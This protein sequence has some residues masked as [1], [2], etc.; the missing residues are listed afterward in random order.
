VARIL[1]AGGRV[2]GVGIGGGEELAARLVIADVMPNALL[3]MTGEALSGWYRK[4]LCRYVY[5]PATLKVDW[6]L[7]GPIPRLNDEVAGAG[8]VHVAGSEQELR[9]TI[10][11]S[12]TG[13]PPRPSPCR[14]SS[15]H[16]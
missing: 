9:S 2:R 16:R 10:A 1:S 15:T 5:G 6:A 8:T 4:A 12:A 3:P 7:A 14:C 11:Q 13:L